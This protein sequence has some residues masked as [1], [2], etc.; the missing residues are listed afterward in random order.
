MSSIYFL[1]G[2]KWRVLARFTILSLPHERLKH[3]SCKVCRPGEIIMD[4]YFTDDSWH[5]KKGVV[6]FI[7]FRERTIDDEWDI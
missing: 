7:N 3:G 6:S 5:V 4:R 2:C 1:K